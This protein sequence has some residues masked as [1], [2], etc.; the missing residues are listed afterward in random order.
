MTE[1]YA[2][3]RSNVSLLGQLLDK[4]IGDHLGDEFLKKIESIRQLSKSSQAGNENAGETL[5][6]VLTNLSDDEL[7]PVTRAFTHFLNL[8]NIAEQFHGISRHCDRSI[9][10]PDPM[11]EL[12]EKLKNAD[13]TEEA[14]QKAVTEL[15]M[16]MVLTAHPTEVTRRTL[17]H[18]HAA[19]NEC[20]TLLEIHDTL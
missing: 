16:D 8:A 15:Q 12:I 3:L 6:N 13:L 4:T 14:I 2:D 10:S 19:I 17:I 18:K 1:Q 20:L 11:T 5:I 9:C 7:L